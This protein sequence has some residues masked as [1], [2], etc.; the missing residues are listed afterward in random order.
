MFCQETTVMKAVITK[1]PTSILQ[2]AYEFTSCIWIEKDGQKVNA[3]G[4]LL[5][6]LKL[7]IRSGAT[8]T[9]IADGSDEKDAVNALVDLVT[10]D[11][12]L[13]IF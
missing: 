8:I 7:D 12:A 2:K 10:N 3:K 11:Y 1:C 5:D 13:D 4:N 9:F 6:I